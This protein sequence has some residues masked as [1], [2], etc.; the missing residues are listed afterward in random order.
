MKGGFLF[1]LTESFGIN[2]FINV[3]V[4]RGNGVIWCWFNNVSDIL[5]AVLLYFFVFCFVTI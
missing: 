5:G 4:K 2:V 3:S 1:Y